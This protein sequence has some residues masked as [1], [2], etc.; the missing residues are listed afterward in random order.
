M[1]TTHAL[2]GLAVAAG[3]AAVTGDATPLLLWAGL[4]GGAFP[5]FDLYWGHRKTL[6]F[7]VYYPL[8]AVAAAG[9]AALTG[10]ALA[11]AATVFLAAAGLHSAMDAFGGGLELRPW[12]GT[13][14]RAVYDHLRGRWLPPRRWV[15]YDGAPEDLGLAAAAAVPGVLA[16]TGTVHTA[17]LAALGVSAAYVLVRKPMVAATEWL[18][19]KTP[20]RVLGYV[21]D[22]FI[23]DLR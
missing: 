22:R 13:S 10:S 9:V 6:H 2:A 8:T 1:A 7:P 17:A 5:D 21:P 3:A 20:D 23:A 16:T 12:E 14:D 4:A 18:V 15:R 11:L 19:A